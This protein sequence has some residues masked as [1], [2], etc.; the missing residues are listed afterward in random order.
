MARLAMGERWTRVAALVAGALL[1][2][3]D[4]P[5]YWVV[6]VLVLLMAAFPIQGETLDSITGLSRSRKAA[7]VAA[8]LVGLLCVP[9][10]QSF[11][12]LPL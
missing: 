5:D 8:V 4:V 6:F 2:L 7:F 10:P 11:A 9:M 12:T 1:L 3:T